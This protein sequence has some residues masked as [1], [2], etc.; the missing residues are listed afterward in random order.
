MLKRNVLLIV[1]SALVFT[2]CA[3]IQ[4]PTSIAKNDVV[5]K[6]D[7]ADNQI[8]ELKIGSQHLSVEVVTS[9]ESIIKGLGGRDE[10]GSDGML[11]VLPE[12]RVAT[13]WM[14]GMRF[15]LDMVWIDGNKIVGI[16]KNVPA[17]LNPNSTNLPIYSSKVSITHVL[18][19]PAGKADEL[20][21]KLG[22][23]VNID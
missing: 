22:E 20:G 3:S 12:R 2:A 1:L 23:M 16:E 15:A 13:F 11:F 18:E 10:I 9:S 4:Q 6:S 5:K 7:I 21:I 8:I 19:L 17:P 14:H